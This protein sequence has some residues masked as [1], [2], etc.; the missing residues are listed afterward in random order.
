MLKNPIQMF[1]PKNN[2]QDLGQ[3]IMQVN[4]DVISNEECYWVSNTKWAHVNMPI[5]Q[6]SGLQ[7]RYVFP[8]GAISTNTDCLNQCGVQK[9]DK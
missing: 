9:M 1:E 5:T 8:P 7:S 3:S 4:T 2:S 6:V